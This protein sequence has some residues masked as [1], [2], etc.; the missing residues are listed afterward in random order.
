[1][2]GI[3]YLSSRSNPLGFL[4]SSEQQ[5]SVGKLAHIIEYAGLAALLHR[6]LSNADKSQ[7]T[8]L[9]SNPID[10]LALPVANNPTSVSPA[11]AQPSPGGYSLLASL[12]IALAYAIF[13]EFHQ[14]FVPGRGFELA[15]IGHDLVGV[16]AALGFIWL[17]NYLRQSRD[18]R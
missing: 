7:N 18:T 9:H 11:S 15:D 8:L 17:R 2:A 6:A 5:E 16:T 12:V 14:E 3:F 1:M 10:P 13:D 4:P